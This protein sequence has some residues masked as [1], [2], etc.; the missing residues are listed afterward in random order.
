MTIRVATDRD[1]PSIIASLDSAFAP[2]RSRYTPAAYEDTV[3]TPASAR[4]R[5]EHM[6]VFVAEGERGEIVGTVAYDAS[7]PPDGH[8]RGMAVVEAMQG[9]GLAAALLDAAERKLAAAGCRRATL[10]TTEVLERA[11]CFYRRRG[12][13]QT[14]VTRDFFG[15]RLIEYAKP[16]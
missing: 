7:R 14:G 12:Y 2:Y 4:R 9:T 15:M 6:T 13:Q 16:L 8:I 1:I 5:L 11:A 3:L 10:D